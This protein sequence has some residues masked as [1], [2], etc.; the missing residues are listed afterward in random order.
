MDALSPEWLSLDEKRDALAVA[1]Q[2]AQVTDLLKREYTLKLLEAVVDG[3]M[4]RNRQEA[5]E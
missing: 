1:G 4:K 2:T 3:K 5:K